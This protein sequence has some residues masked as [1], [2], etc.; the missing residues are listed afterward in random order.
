M[1]AKTERHRLG[2][3]VCLAIVLPCTSIA[4]S[5]LAFSTDAHA[6]LQLPGAFTR[7]A[8]SAP[9]PSSPDRPGSSTRDAPGGRTPSYAGKAVKIR[10][11]SEKTLAGS[12]LM[13]NGRR[14]LIRFG[15]TVEGVVLERMVLSGDVISR[16]GDTCKVEVPGAPFNARFDGFSDGLR[17]Y[18]VEVKSCPFTFVVL[19]GAMIVT[20]SKSSISNALGAGTCVFKEKDCRGYLG[21][22]WGPSGRSF[23]K[24]TSRSIEK[25][26]G[27]SERDARSNF[28]ALLRAAGRDRSRI[29][30]VA[31]DQAGFSARREVRCR[32][33]LREHVH[34]YCASRITQARA[35]RLGAR[36]NERILQAA[37]ERK[38]RRNTGNNKRS[39]TRNR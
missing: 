36:L 32:D 8:P 24:K 12:A 10:A 31:A 2:I 20:Y 35:I 39:R 6:Q 1:M 25:A 29:R 21:G 11:P 19:D 9:S 16:P 27:R 28:R 5:P 26:R 15:K 33:Y 34:G 13:H 3:A 17:R 23:G 38:T 4:L 30:A 22:I 37:N 18:K 7:T 14:G